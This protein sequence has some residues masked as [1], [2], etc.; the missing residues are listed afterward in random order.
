MA[1]IRFNIVNFS[2]YFKGIMD[3]FNKK[4]GLILNDELFK[5]DLKYEDGGIFYVNFRNGYKGKLKFIISEFID[6]IL[7]FICEGSENL[8]RIIQKQIK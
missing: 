6:L 1:Y 8:K 5:L 7:S 4:K 3:G 2:V